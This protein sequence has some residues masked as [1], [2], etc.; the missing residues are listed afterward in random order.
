M[1]RSLKQ[2]LV[3]GTTGKD[4]VKSTNA[5]GES[6]STI[7]ST[8]DATHEGLLSQV[9]TPSA[10]AVRERI[11]GLIELVTQHPDRSDAVDIV[12]IHGLNGHY[13]NT[14]IDEKTGCNWLSDKS[15]L[16]KDI[17]NA[18]ILSFGYNSVT[19]FSRSNTDIR[20]FASTLLAALRAKRRTGA[21]KQRPLV[22]ICHG[23]GGLVFKQ[24]VVRGHEQDGYYG[25]MLERIQGVVFM[26]TPHRGL[27]LSVWDSL[28]PRIV[29]AATLGFKCNTKL[30]KDLKAGSEMLDRISESFAHRGAN[31]KIRSFYET[32]RMPHH[33]RC[34]VDKESARLGWSNEL[35]IAS[36]S[37]HANICRFKS[38]D[39]P[40]YETVIYELLDIID[41]AED[42]IDTAREF[43]PAT[44]G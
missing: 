27:N 38:R 10:Q 29:R 13:K 7:Q 26:A 1:R 24:L 17:P 18:R 41:V 2:F 33:S 36:P 35:D 32:E 39:D 25:P 9:T 34:I 31:L 44:R 11:H 28:G 8:N 15:C 12:A 5:N 4:N 37:D 6:L 14:W 30:I 20:D 42:H 19:Y 43:S 40:R 23:L 16:P 22:F 21:E 3:P